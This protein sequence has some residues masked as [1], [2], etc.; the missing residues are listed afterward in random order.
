MQKIKIIKI[1]LLIKYLF[2]Y[3]IYTMDFP[4]FS[5]QILRQGFVNKYVVSTKIINFIRKITKRNSVL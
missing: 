4:L 2:E 5:I 1:S 3:N